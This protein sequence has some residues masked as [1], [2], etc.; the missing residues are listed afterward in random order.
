MDEGEEGPDEDGERQFHHD[1]RLVAQAGPCPH[2]VAREQ[3]EGRGHEACAPDL[4][5]SLVRGS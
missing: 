4:S 2:R 3:D 5:P 1:E